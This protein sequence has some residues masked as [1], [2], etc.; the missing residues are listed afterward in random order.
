MNS[1]RPVGGWF[2][3]NAS[4][5]AM[6]GYTLP[7]FLTLLIASHM[8]RKVAKNHGV[9]LPH[10][11]PI[12]GP[13]MIWWPFGMIGFASLPRSDARLWPDRSS[14]GNTGLSAP[15]V[16]VLS[17]M[18][19]IFVGL[20]LTPEIVVIN[21]APFVVELPFLANILACL[22]YTSPSPRDRTRSRMPSSA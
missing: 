5:D 2:V 14:L 7:I 8:Q 1:G 11:F 13:A 21:S 10:L 9:H 16:M 18:V 15:F 22:L 19:L 20:L 6:V 12:P 17:G 4:L 3:E